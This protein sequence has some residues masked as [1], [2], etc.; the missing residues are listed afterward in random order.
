MK[1]VTQ[2][3][4]ALVYTITGICHLQIKGVV[5]ILLKSH[6]KYGHVTRLFMKKCKWPSLILFSQNVFDVLSIDKNKLG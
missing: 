1:F 3:V 2:S 5:S 6:R 4:I